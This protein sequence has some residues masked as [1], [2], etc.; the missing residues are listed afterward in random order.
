[1]N[2]TWLNRLHFSTWRRVRGSVT[3]CV[4]VLMQLDDARDKHTHCVPT[5]CLSH[6]RRWLPMSVSRM[7]LSHN[8][9]QEGRPACCINWTGGG[10]GRGKVCSEIKVHRHT[11]GHNNTNNN[12]IIIINN[13]NNN[14][15]NNN[16]VW[17][18]YSAYPRYTPCSKRFTK[19][20]LLVHKTQV[21]QRTRQQPVGRFYNIGREGRWC[22]SPMG[23]S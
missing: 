9:M 18:L 23:I 14:K 3:R 4:Y 16:N 22:S 2:C 8:T 1:M 19:H 6:T 5:V 15:D 13:N 20:F 21:T 7:H 11:G 12:I 10:G 17:H